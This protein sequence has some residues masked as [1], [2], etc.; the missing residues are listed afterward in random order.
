MEAQATILALCAVC[1]SWPL[2]CSYVGGPYAQGPSKL[3][4]VDGLCLDTMD[5]Q[6][7]GILAELCRFENVVYDFHPCALVEV[8][9]IT[10]ARFIVYL[11]CR[12]L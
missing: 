11:V 10:A 4:G 2:T 6:H 1:A 12:Q 8:V 5:A 3:Q 9:V 7:G